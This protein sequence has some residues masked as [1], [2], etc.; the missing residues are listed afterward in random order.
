[1]QKVFSSRTLFVRHSLKESLA[2]F[3]DVR[4]PIS[5]PI[6]TA[7]FFQLLPFGLFSSVLFEGTADGTFFP[8]LLF[9]GT[10]LGFG[11]I[12]SEDCMVS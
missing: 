9:P 11:L 2:W 1:M 4:Q 7:L 8:P 12:V 10:G 3:S 6:I 5:T